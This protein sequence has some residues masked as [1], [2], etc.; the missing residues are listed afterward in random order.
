MKKIL[1]VAIVM[2]ISVSG[3]A[4]TDGNY[5]YSKEFIWGINKNS[6]GGLIGGFMMRWSRS[7]GETKFRSMGIEVMNV[8]NSKE[9][10]I[11]NGQSRFIFGKTNYLYSIRAQY[12]FD[13][14]LFKKAPQQGV[15]I[16]FNYSG[17]PTLGVIAPYYVRN[18]DGNS[19]QFS[20]DDFPN[21]T[22]IVSTGH[23]FEGLS[24]SS[25]TVG[26]NARAGLLF[27]LGAFKSNV[28]GFEIGALVEAFPSKIELMPREKNNAFFLS[29]Y[30]TLFYG[31]RK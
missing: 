2:V 3:Y 27:E 15:Q 30:V 29:A 9:N 12:G 11:S 21:H 5:D 14:I 10:R 26:L 6:N 16:I 20:F 17:G 25:L 31:N 23:I 22:S 1:W 24:E 7:V 4:Q 13:H 18:I 28:T 19:Q 8:K